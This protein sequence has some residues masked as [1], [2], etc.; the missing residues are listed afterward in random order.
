MQVV[1]GAAEPAKA[2]GVSVRLDMGTLPAQVEAVH[3]KLKQLA[4]R[5]RL[6]HTPAG[7]AVRVGRPG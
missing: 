1:A 2:G 6:H 3:A 4:G 7:A 5:G